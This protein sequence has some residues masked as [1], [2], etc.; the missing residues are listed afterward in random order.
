MKLPILLFACLVFATEV[1][2]GQT[3]PPGRRV[4][5]VTHVGPKWDDMRSETR[6]IPGSVTEAGISFGVESPTSGIEFDVSATDWR[7][8]PGGTQ[9]YRF[10]GQTSIYSQKGHIYESTSTKRQRSPEAGV[11][12]RKNL[13]LHD[14]VILTWLVGGS[15]AYR[16]NELVQI[17]KEVL[18]DGSLVEVHRSNHRYVRSYVAGVIGLETIVKLSRQVAIVPRLRVT[19]F[20]AC[21][22][23]SG[24]APRLLLVRPQVGVRWTF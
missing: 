8:Q 18:P 21:L 16:P 5:V 14:A 19:A 12:F 23:T 22:D 13:R 24:S 17:K 3:P 10:A 15:F 2:Q 4:F 11:L 9:R 6:R 7:V 20:P 1:V